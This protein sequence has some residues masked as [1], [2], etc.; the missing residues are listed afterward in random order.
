M[1]APTTLPILDRTII[2]N[3][4]RIYFANSPIHL[5]VQNSLQDSSILSATVYLWIWNGEQDAVLGAANFT[6]F[7]DKVSA[8]DDYINFQIADL[9][10]PFINPQF[11]YNELVN[12]AIANQGVFW[13]VV[14]D[15]T[16]T[17]GTV[18]T[19]YHTNFATLGY[20]WNYEQNA[21]GNNGIS[22]YGS[23]G[24]LDASNKYYDND[25][26]NYI[27]QSFNLTNS[28]DVANT[29]NMITVTDIDTDTIPSQWLRCAKETTLIVFLNKLGLWEMFTSFG[30]VT[31]NSKV[32]RE[33]S[34]NGFRDPSQIDNTYIHSKQQNGLN[35]EQSYIINTGSLTD[36]MISIIEEIVYSPKVYLI[37]FKGDYQTT[38]TIGITVDNTYI[39]A[40]DTTIT[41]DSQTTTVESLGKYKTHQQIPV[42]VS[43]TDFI[44]KTRIN[45]KVAI[46]YNIKFDET[47]NKLLSIR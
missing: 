12:P 47:N 24:F 1:A 7:K 41:V 5:R 45:D 6:L 13:Q 15:I 27:S 8:N 23:T 43:D 16:S 33:I 3:E 34:N 40:D 38:T 20:R 37:K 46:D 30:K 26:H 28:I 29:S 35:V 31:V 18:R 25:I 39:T 32:D 9:I 10:K 11:A 4:N 2:N 42:M 21:I 44:R 19:N 17:A 14:I 36:D 22:N